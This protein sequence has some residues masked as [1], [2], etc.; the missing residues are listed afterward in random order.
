MRL[1]RAYPDGEEEPSPPA[2]VDAPARLAGRGWPDAPGEAG[3]PETAWR[4]LL[5]A[6]QAGRLDAAR[7]LCTPAGWAS[8]QRWAGGSQARLA[9][10]G[11]AWAG[12]PMRWGESKDG[13]VLGLYGPPI[14]EASFQFVL[15]G[16]EW[17]L[18]EWSPGE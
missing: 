3:D 6:L 15:G 14:K 17:R 8:L 1:R 7:R 18:D 16:K 4:S 5:W 10:L 12:Q 13:K 9:Q 11:D 2:A